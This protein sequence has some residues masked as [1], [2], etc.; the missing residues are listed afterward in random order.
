MTKFLPENYAGLNNGILLKTAEYGTKQMHFDL[1]H[2]NELSSVLGYD[3]LPQNNL[4]VI[5]GLESQIGLDY[6]G[7]QSLW[8]LDTN[9]IRNVKVITQDPMGKYTYETFLPADNK[10]KV[11]AYEAVD[12]ERPGRDN[13]PIRLKLSKRIGSHGAIFT[14]SKLAGIELRVG[15]EPINGSDDTG[16]WYTTYQITTNNTNSWVDPRYL[17][18]GIYVCA[19]GSVIGERGEL[20][21]DRSVGGAKRTYYNYVGNGMAQKYFSVTRFAAKTSVPTDLPKQVGLD[22][23]KRIVEIHMMGGAAANQKGL[24]G[25]D[26]LEF[27]Q[28]NYG[29]GVEG[30]K[31]MSKDI[32]HSVFVPE[33]ELY[34]MALINQEINH[35]AIWGNGG[36]IRTQGKDP[37]TI[38]LPVGLFRQIM[39][40][41]NRFNYNLNDFRID[42]LVSFLN[43]GLRNRT[44]IGNMMTVKVKTGSGGMS[45]VKP[46][47]LAKY[48]QVST[49]M[50]IFGNEFIYNKGGKNLNLGF[51]MEFDRITLPM[52]KMELVFEYAEELDANMGDYNNIDN[53]IVG[54][55]GYRLSSYA[56]IVDDITGMGNN[57]IELYNEVNKDFHLYHVDGKM[58]YLGDSNRHGSVGPSIPGYEVYIEKGYKAYQVVDPQRVWM[59]LPINPKTRQPFGTFMSDAMYN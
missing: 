50:T 37:Q 31:N 8:S 40:S 25:N 39:K 34:Y 24:Q 33:L 11:L 32:F 45:I 22:M 44:S 54:K 48:N 27:T 42:H 6:I 9:G 23:H 4:G 16:Y 58:P 47:I 20:Y 56:F 2:I 30:A 12:R 36:T 38:I 10:A 1:A 18:E 28:K 26:L 41:A 53:P 59:M 43:N 57:I 49:N 7:G 21:D 19:T 35:Y 46:Q 52:G 29:K 55:D 3:S 15:D 5:T 13:S 51:R 17:Q 14:F